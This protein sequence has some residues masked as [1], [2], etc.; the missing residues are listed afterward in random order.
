M[1]ENEKRDYLAKL[2]RIVE[3]SS[4]ILE[5]Q[6]NRVITEEMRDKLEKLREQAKL[7]YKKLKSEEFEIAVVG[8]E[9]AGKSS[10]SNA[11]IGMPALPTDDGRCTYTS[12]CIRPWT[13]D[14][15]DV[16]FYSK[17]EFALSFHQKL[18]KLGILNADS[19]TLDLKLEEYEELF[20]NCDPAKRELYQNSLH[21]D[22]VD[23]LEHKEELRRYIGNGSRHFSAEQ[24]KSDEFRAFITDPGRAI[25]VKDVVI[26]STQ[27]KDMPNAILYDVP[28]FNSPTAMHREQ[29][30]Q[31]MDSADAIIMVTKAD[32]PNLVQEVLE[33]FKKAGRDGLLSD[34]LFVFANKADRAT[35]L[36]KNKKITYSEWI[37]TRKILPPEN[38]NRIVFGSANAYLGGSTANGLEARS[39]LEKKGISDGICEL[40]DMLKDYYNNERFKVLTK[41]IDAILYEMETL[42]SGV[43]EQFVPVGS[44]Y[45]SASYNELVLAAYSSLKT[46]LKDQLNEL[47]YQVNECAREEH[48]L[49]NGISQGIAGL[50]TPEKYDLHDEEIDKIKKSIAGI[51]KAHQPQNLDIKIREQRFDEMYKAFANEILRCTGTHHQKVCSAI[52]EIFLSNMHV[53]SSRAEYGRLKSEVEE[54]C[55]LHSDG[56]TVYYQSLIER[57]ARDVFEIQIKFALVDRLEKF[58]EEASNFFSLGVFYSAGQNA[59]DPLAYIE[60]RPKDSPMWRLLLYPECASSRT[61]LKK[62]LQD[63]TGLKNV[64]STVLHLLEQ[65]AMSKGGAAAQV[66]EMAFKAVPTHVL[67]EAEL[68][69][70]VVDTLH[71]IIGQSDSDP[72]KI[73]D[74]SYY[75]KYVADKHQDYSYDLVRQEFHDDIVALQIVL[76]DAFVPAVNI[77]KAFSARESLLIEDTIRLLDCEDFMRFVARNVD[78]IEAA[79]VGKIKE[80]ET[81]R[82]LDAA[83]INE[84]QAI[85]SQITAIVTV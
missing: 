53:D 30:F 33:V 29:T 16:C 82:A 80:A 73:L 68:Y 61:E 57:F 2:E 9:K 39:T 46:K 18:E 45:Q 77:D 4:K 21:Q 17:Q 14:E 5:L 54:L 6:G 25:A 1:T 63:L 13:E 69:S 24:L 40:R 27:L 74:G 85:L 43:K 32:E 64:S 81:Q 48:P 10:F 76:M 84:I 50:I 59:K 8:L 3:G 83:V 72:G 37:D 79:K 12:T 58:K 15:A 55:S 75:Q 35:D 42:F 31:K 47:R 28:G 67:G 49:R 65:M 41:R 23:T 26:H 62:K 52:E 20:K 60:E 56:D 51:G 38:R 22:I 78:T 66:M 7:L 71:D 70:K 11:L 36:E 34:K 44:T 19:Y